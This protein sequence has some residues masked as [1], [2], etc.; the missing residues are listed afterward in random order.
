MVT[1]HFY[2]HTIGLLLFNASGQL[3]ASTVEMNLKTRI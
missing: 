3:D 1:T 2:S